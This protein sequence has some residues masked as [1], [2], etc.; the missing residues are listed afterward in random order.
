MPIG[1]VTCGISA[2]NFFWLFSALGL[3]ELLE[4]AILSVILGVF[5]VVGYRL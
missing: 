1:I 3:R 4:V 5:C 2:V